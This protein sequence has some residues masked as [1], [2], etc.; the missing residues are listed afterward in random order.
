MTLL[1]M[2]MTF[3][4]PVER[5]RCQVRKLIKHVLL[6]FFSF[7]FKQNMIKK[8]GGKERLLIFTHVA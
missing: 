2:G 3:F 4:L 5:K 8:K 1:K 6:F 7:F